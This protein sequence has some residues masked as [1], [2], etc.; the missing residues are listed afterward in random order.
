MRMSR[1]DSELIKEIKEG[2]QG[3]IDELISRYQKKVYNIALGMSGDYNKA[4]DVSQEA[5]V[6]VIRNIGDFREESSFW[7][8]IYRIT[9]NAFYDYA[10]KAKVRSRVANI[11]DV[12][13][14]DDGPVFEIKDTL[15]IEE[16]Y[17]KKA[18]KEAIKEGMEKLT[19]IQR[20]VFLLKN[21]EGY[22]I[23][24]I[25]GIL[26]ISDGTVKSH[27]SRAMEKVKAA[28]DKEAV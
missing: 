20:Q 26:K 8:Y 28:V 2:K 9:V 10:R 4:W 16:D 27:L 14:D 18:M 12:E 17:E 5:F 24:E 19:E 21:M 3:A 25:S 15:S 6:K 13:K 1:E 7:T 22:K 11:T 23:R